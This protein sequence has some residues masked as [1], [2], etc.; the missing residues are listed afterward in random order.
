MAIYNDT[1]VTYS[2]SQHE[3]NSVSETFDVKASD[4]VVLSDSAVKSIRPSNN[5]PFSLVDVIVNKNMSVVKLDTFSLI[6]AVSKNIQSSRDEPLGLSESVI[7]TVK[8]IKDESFGLIDSIIN[9]NIQLNKGDI[10]VLVDAISKSISVSKV[11]MISLLDEE[12]LELFVL[13]AGL[14]VNRKGYSGKEPHDV[15]KVQWVRVRRSDTDNKPIN[16]PF[17]SQEDGIM[18]NSKSSKETKDND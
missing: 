14:N 7:K 18:L 5:D 9:K 16:D 1:V 8:P 6:D 12:T 10:Y 11:D 4:D 3:Y 17:R 15:K 2:N 13:P